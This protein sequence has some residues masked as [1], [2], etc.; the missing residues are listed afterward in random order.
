MKMTKCAEVLELDADMPIPAIRGKVVSVGKKRS[1]P[2]NAAEA[3]SYQDFKLKDDTGT[4]DGCLVSRED[5]LEV[6]QEYVFLCYHGERGLSGVKVKHKE[7]NGKFTCYVWVTGSG[8]IVPADNFTEGDAEPA[9]KKTVKLKPHKKAPVE[10]E[11]TGTHSEEEEPAP[12]IKKG[13]LSDARVAIAKARVLLI[14]CEKAA[15]LARVAME[16]HTGETIPVDRVGTMSSTLFIHITRQFPDLV[17]GMPLKS[18]L[19]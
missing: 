2:P 14:E 10:E 15:H 4:V 5:E 6:G 7:Y 1:S 8:E 3:W 18:D 12:V 13:A 9:E 19:D 11:D 17:D 16:K